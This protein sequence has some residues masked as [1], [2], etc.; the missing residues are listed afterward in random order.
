MGIRVAYDMDTQPGLPRITGGKAM[1][2]T[3]DKRAYAAAR[4]LWS[5]DYI[6]HS[7][8]FSNYQYLVLSKPG[9]LAV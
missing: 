9:E 2:D 3:A 8:Q 7:P 5:P 4:R 1:T 6:E